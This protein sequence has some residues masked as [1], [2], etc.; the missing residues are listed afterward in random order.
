M[1][2]YIQN[3]AS[4]S[5]LANADADAVRRMVE[6]STDQ[7]RHNAD[8]SYMK[9]LMNARASLDNDPKTA[10]T[11]PASVRAEINKIPPMPRQQA[12]GASSGASS[13]Q[14]QQNPS[15]SSNSGSG[16]G[17][18]SPRSS[19]PPPNPGPAPGPS[20]GSQGNPSGS[21]QNP[22]NSTP[23]PKPSTPNSNSSSSSDSSSSSSGSSSSDDSSSSSGGGDTTT[24]NGQTFTQT[25][26]GLYIPKH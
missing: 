12:H 24:H 19:T 6:F 9:S 10:G 7:A 1:A 15:G 11:V 8:N 21:G 22:Q 25:S 17:G 23:P 5:G 3:K 13:G 16:S 14:G 20:G 26:S 4:G 18:P 2:D